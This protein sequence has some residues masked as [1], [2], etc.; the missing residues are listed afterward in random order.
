MPGSSNLGNLKTEKWEQLQDVADRFESAWRQAPGPQQAPDL[1]SFL[2]PP[3]DGLRST[4]LQ[5]L[6][7]TDLEIRWRQGQVYLLENY[8]ER[9][10]DLGTRDTVSPQ[11]IFEE[12]VIRQRHGDRPTAESYQARF[13]GRYSDFERLMREQPLPTMATAVPTPSYKPAQKPAEQVPAPNQVAAAKAPPEA[14]AEQDSHP[15]DFLPGYKRVRKIGSGGFGEVWEAEAP[16]G[17]PVAIKMLF[18]SVD[19]EESRR[20]LESMEIIKTLRHPFL[21]STQSIQSWRNRLYI[22]MELADQSL[23]DRAKECRK[24]GQPGIPL[25]ELLN[26]FREASDALDFLHAQ[27]VLHRDIKPDN[28]LSVQHHTKLADFGLARLHESER[29]MNASGSGTPAYMPPEVWN[30][31]VCP[32]SDQYALALTYAELRLDRRLYGS[33]DMMQLMFDH[34]NT[35]PNLDPLP[36][37]EQKV[38]LR[39]LAKDH[40][41]RYPTCRAFI[42]ALI[43]ALAPIIGKT[44]EFSLSGPGSA[45]SGKTTEGLSEAPAVEQQPTRSRQAAAA[46]VNAIVAAK[47]GGTEAEVSAGPS[48]RSPI[49][50][51]PP[52]VQR[53]AL[54]GLASLV[55]LLGGAAVAAYL[56]RGNRTP[57]EVDYRPHNCVKAEGA[58]ITTALGKKLYNRID[59]VIPN[60]GTHI[61]FILIPKTSNNDPATFYMMEDKVSV[62]LFKKFAEKNPDAVHDDRWKKPAPGDDSPPN[63]EPLCPVVSVSVED[64]YRFATWL[65]GD[66]PTLAEWE[67]AA[68]QKEEPL[69]GE[70]P[71][72]PN[73]QAKE[74]GLEL[75]RYDD[76]KHL[77]DRG[78]PFPEE[79]LPRPFRLVPMKPA[80]TPIQDMSPLGPRYMASNG[81]EFTCDVEQ[82][83][84]HYRVPLLNFTP[85]EKRRKSEAFDMQVKC[86]GGKWDFGLRYRYKDDGTKAT[87]TGYVKAQAS[88]GFRVVLRLTD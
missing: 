49:S 29:S 20:E 52:L 44:A 30:G 31:K 32:N 81:A 76:G 21:L 87:A 14:K 13:P 54:L 64:A 22:V 35:A 75:I 28:I 57:S 70:G 80:G 53:P 43:E 59:Y 82:G 23:R 69:K 4:A 33:K 51:S 9:F 8:L 46:A 19:D 16:G 1:A 7:K 41:K 61:R 36:E 63:T 78:N 85:E 26:Y 71:Y 50:T 24:A 73:K 6:I 45:G 65:D 39:A 42:Q 62:A 83:S 77:D 60:D 5:E 47:S 72:I 86:G 79:P 17:V 84:N 40:N 2:P 34:M 3:E 12:Y 48:S 56:L 27:K 15:G 10:P 67:K 18:R 25:V 74:R 38:L 58:E 68:G 55:L 88:I 66:L 37:V 11:L